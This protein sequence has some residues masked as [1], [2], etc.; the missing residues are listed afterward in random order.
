[1]PEHFHLLMSE[2]EVGDP[3]VVMKVI[4]QRF[5]RRLNQ[6]RKPTSPLQTALLGLDS[7][8]GLAETFL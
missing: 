1:M 8:P 5:A 7:R 2:P 3:S 6:R 4:K